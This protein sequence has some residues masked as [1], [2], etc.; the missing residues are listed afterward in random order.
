VKPTMK[1]HYLYVLSENPINP[2]YPPR[3]LVDIEA[4]GQLTLTPLNEL[5]DLGW[6]VLCQISGTGPDLVYLLK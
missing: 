6:N 2:L 5:S 4:S 1:Y 3:V